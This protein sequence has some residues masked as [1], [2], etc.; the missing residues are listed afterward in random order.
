M[1]SLRNPE[2]LVN[3]EGIKNSQSYYRSNPKKYLTDHDVELEY[4]TAANVFSFNRFIVDFCCTY[5]D[6]IMC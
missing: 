1:S 6:K 2:E 4:Y 3:D 5:V